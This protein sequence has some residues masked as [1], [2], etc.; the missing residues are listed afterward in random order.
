MELTIE[1]TPEAKDALDEM[2]PELRREAWERIHLLST[3]PVHPHPSLNA[4]RL[5][6]LEGIHDKWECYVTMA[7]RIIYDF[8]DGMLRIWRV[9]DHSIVDRARNLSFAAGTCFQRAMQDQPPVSSDE[10]LFQIPVAWT[11]QEKYAEFPWAHLLPAHLRVLGVPAGSVKAVR[12]CPDFATLE[13]LGLPQQ[14]C[15]WL[16]DLA[17]SDA[18]AAE[19]FSPDDLYFKTTLS[20]LE[21]YCTGK[22]RNLM[23]NLE[24]EQEQYRR[25]TASGPLL[26][27]GCAG[28]GKTT[29]ALYRALDQALEGK[30][31]LF[32]T[33]SAS[34]AEVARTLLLE[35]AGSPLPPEL[36]V[37]TVS[38]W[39]ADFVTARGR[40]WTGSSR[41]QREVFLKKAIMAAGATARGML[42]DPGF[43]SAEVQ[44]VIKA[45][46]LSE[47]QYQRARRHGRGKALQE[48]QRHVVW[49]I[50]QTYQQELEAHAL[51]DWE[52]MPVIAL[53]EL[54]RCTLERPFDHVIVDEAQD[55][56]A[57]EIR[58]AS[59]L[60]TSLFLVGDA[61]QSIY[62]R[63]YTWREAGLELQGHSYSL[64]RNFRNTRQV[65]EAAAALIRH[66]ETLVASED[67]VDPQFT[68]RNGPEARRLRAWMARATTSLPDPVSPRMSTGTSDRAT[69]STRSITCR[70]P[71]SAPMIASL[72]SWRPRRVSSDRRSAS[73]A[74]RISRISRRRWSFS[75]ATENGS[76]KACASA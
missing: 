13:A 61:A 74:S 21:G 45:G 4:H 34:L 42:A 7:Y 65:A 75:R 40:K 27:R 12:E 68:R 41:E 53:Q 49:T 8:T 6:A 71:A 28:S 10:A 23:L 43:I 22:I 18:S 52:D 67:W 20:S 64:K 37:S 63:G 50:Y 56:T 48:G 58:L 51:V 36:E 2:S 1:L 70:S 5:R 30:H 14:A 32:L 24:P 72:I 26:L 59:R 60:G 62:T 55:L 11:I 44:S 57:T 47:E 31:V 76:S 38:Q 54:D 25:R 16:E 73:A 15:A 9:G 46:G 69:S 39:V 19:L 17:T 66:N 35:L 33:Y 3:N 29:V